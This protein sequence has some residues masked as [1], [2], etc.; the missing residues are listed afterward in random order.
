MDMK[1]CNR[2]SHRIRDFYNDTLDNLLRLRPNY[3]LSRV[4]YILP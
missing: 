4:Q 3:A 2:Y 1:N